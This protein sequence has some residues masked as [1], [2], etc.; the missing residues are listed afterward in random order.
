MRVHQDMP[1][2]SLTAPGLIFCTAVTSIRGGSDPVR[3]EDLVHLSSAVF[4]TEIGTYMGHRT[5]DCKLM[6]GNLTDR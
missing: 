2:H 6:D 1:W 4:A 3:K 5:K